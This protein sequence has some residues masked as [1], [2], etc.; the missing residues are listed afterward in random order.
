MYYGW[1]WA[2]SGDYPYFGTTDVNL[3]VRECVNSAPNGPRDFFRLGTL[4]DPG[5]VHR[6]HFWSLHTSGGNFL[7]GDGSIRFVTY[8]AGAG[9]ASGVTLMEA[10]ASRAGGET[11]NLP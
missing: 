8:A 7:F 11:A 1:M 5:D 2:G 9:T 10:L 3:G 6:F 4:S